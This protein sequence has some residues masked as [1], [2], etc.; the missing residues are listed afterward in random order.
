VRHCVHCAKENNGQRQFTHHLFSGIT[1]IES[2]MLLIILLGLIAKLALVCYGCD[3][4]TSEVTSI[5][6]NQVGIGLR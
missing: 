6:W 1:G 4:G 5:D 3:I 2:K